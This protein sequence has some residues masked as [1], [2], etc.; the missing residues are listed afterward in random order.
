MNKYRDA[1]TFMKEGFEWV[2]TFSNR[3]TGVMSGDRDEMF[4]RACEESGI[5]KSRGSRAA[6]E[7][8]VKKLAAIEY[9]L[10]LV[11]LEDSEGERLDGADSDSGREVAV[12]DRE[13]A[14]AMFEFD[15]TYKRSFV[16]DE[17]TNAL[18]ADGIEA[19]AYFMSCFSDEAWYGDLPER[20]KVSNK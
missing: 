9:V 16:T 17:F 7:T 3:T 11:A 1:L 6:L 13:F 2:L 4:R 10:G 12:P 5:D 14:L 8:A 20:V 18:Y 15:Y 19:S